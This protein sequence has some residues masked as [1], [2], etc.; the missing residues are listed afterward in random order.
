MHSTKTQ[1]QQ[2]WA[3]PEQTEGL[4]SQLHLKKNCV[5]ARPSLWLRLETGVFYPDRGDPFFLQLP[6]ERAVIKEAMF[7]LELD[8]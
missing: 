5:E 8:V 2:L 3:D 6:E 7:G 4:I 1:E